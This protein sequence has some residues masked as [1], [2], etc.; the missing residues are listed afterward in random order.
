MKV[1]PYTAIHQ[2]LGAKMAEFA[3]YNMPIEYTGIT[4]EHLCVC[5]KLGVFDVSHMGEF[6]VSGK[7]ALA[8][9]Q[10]IVS[11]DAS[12]LHDGKVQYACLMHPTGGVV[13]DLLIY[14]FNEEKYLLVVNA[15]NVDKDFAVACKY[16][17]Q[18]G[19][20]A[21][22]T[23]INASEEYA[24]LAIQGPLAMKAMQ[25]LCA[26][27][28]ENMEY[29]TFKEVEL[30]GVKNAIF[31]TTGY[32]GAGGC[33]VYVKNADAIQLWNAVME[34][35]KEFDIQPVGLGA[36]D[37][38]RL[39]MGYCLY[40]HEL[41]DQATPLEAGLGW[42][43]KFTKDFVGKA[44]LLK[45][46]AE[47]VQRKLVGFMLQDRGVAR[48]E[49]EICNEQREKI[50]AVTSGT[51]SPLMKNSIGMGYVKAEYAAVGNKIYIKVRD[52]FLAAGIVKPPFRKM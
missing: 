8:F 13:D 27:P 40:G 37:T 44:A 46:K 14:R 36:R 48:A 15:A 42:V 41:N 45:Q 1:T 6:W 19:L 7:N 30:A 5:H 9:I 32:T 11:N 26:E 17:G 29:Y 3:G 51:M 4:D 33:E 34:A 52:K 28:L 43:T 31:S 23:L 2:A 22:K 50:G 12:V 47:G 39:E 38:L 35:G 24:Q 20:E 16:A 10:Y 18:F 21:G 25:K 49:Y